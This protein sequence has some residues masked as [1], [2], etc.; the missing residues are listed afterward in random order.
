M[1]KCLKKSDLKLRVR[2]ATR[3]DIPAMWQLHR[4][5]STS[6][7]S[8]QQYEVLFRPAPT[9][10]SGYFMLVVED[11]AELSS[12]AES[13][14]GSSVIAHLVAHRVRSEWNLQYA[15][16]AEGSRGRGVG[17]YLLKEFVSYV[18]G[19]GGTQILLE[20]RA[21]NRSAR[22]LYKSIGFTESG[23]RKGY[24]PDPPEDAILYELSL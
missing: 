6:P 16:V 3:A 18:R 8:F 24:Y 13:A 7:W 14:S 4:E 2:R 9:E 22:R 1:P 21:S 23:L 12:V 20:V 17:T 11:S 5:A 10:Q 15:V 19:V